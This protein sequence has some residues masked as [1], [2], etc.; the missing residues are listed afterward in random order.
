[1]EKESEPRFKLNF[2]LEYRHPK[3]CFNQ[4]RIYTAHSNRTIRIFEWYE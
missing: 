4:F 1:M 3:A 2:N